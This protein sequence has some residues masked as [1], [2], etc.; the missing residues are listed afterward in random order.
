MYVQ[1]AR[2]LFFILQVSFTSDRCKY[3]PRWPLGYYSSVAKFFFFCRH[4]PSYLI[5]TFQR[6]FE[7]KFRFCSWHKIQLNENFFLLLSLC[8]WLRMKS[9]YH[10]VTLINSI[11]SYEWVIS[12]SFRPTPAKVETL[13]RPTSFVFF[14]N[15]S[16]HSIFLSYIHRG[17][18][19][20]EKNY[21]STRF[22][23]PLDTRNR[24]F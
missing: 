5:T 16:Q 15:R 10:R 23:Q 19:E 2:L 21:S 1:K 6:I 20:E 11:F 3:Q 7:M 22:V 24:L 4:F 8:E 12:T 9:E 13:K 18:Y 14:S 17:S